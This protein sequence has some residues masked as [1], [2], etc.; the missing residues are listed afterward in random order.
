MNE[1]RVHSPP[2]ARRGE[3]H[4]PDK[5]DAACIIQGVLLS[6]KAPRDRLFYT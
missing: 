2:S 5:K 3:K 4:I 6:T 1:S